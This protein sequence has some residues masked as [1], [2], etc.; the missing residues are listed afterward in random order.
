VIGWEEA[1]DWSWPWTR[2]A[3]GSPRLNA[4]NCAPLH[5]HTDRVAA[6]RHR[7]GPLPVPGA[8]WSAHPLLQVGHGHAAAVRVGHLN[9]AAAATARPSYAAARSVGRTLPA[10]AG[11]RGPL[12]AA[13]GDCSARRAAAGWCRPPRHAALAMLRS[14]PGGPALWTSGPPVAASAS[15]RTR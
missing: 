8:A 13:A 5:M 10:A 1:T 14:R 2:T 7:D 6:T 15:P 3:C 4:V 12:L 9:G 11:W